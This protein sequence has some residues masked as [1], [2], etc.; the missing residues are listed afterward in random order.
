MNRKSSESIDTAQ[1]LINKKLFTQSV[2]CSYYAVIQLM[3][4]KL[5]TTKD[6]PISYEDQRSKIGN[7]GGSHEYLLI[8]IKKRLNYKDAKSFTEEFRDLKS[9]RVDADYTQRQFNDIEGCECK[10][11]ADKLI[12]KLQNL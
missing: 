4:Y 8:E 2:H 9:N 7:A 10:A 11:E 12:K 6:N 1:E 5:A 3:Q